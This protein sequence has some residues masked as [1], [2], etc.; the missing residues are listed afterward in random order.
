MNKAGKNSH[1]SI[2]AMGNFD[3]VHRGHQKIFE[4]LNT[5]A[6]QEGHRSKVVTFTPNPKVYFKREKFLITTY[7]QKKN[8]LETQGADQVLVIDFP[9]VMNLPDEQFIEEY[10]LE[11]YHMK[12]IVLGENFRFGKG[13]E[14]NI[15]SLKRAA[16]RLNFRFTVVKPVML[17]EIR[18]SSSLIRQQLNE[19]NI[20]LSNRMLGRKYFIE[21]V[22]V[23]G[24][25][26]GRQLGFPT[27]NIETPN[28]L[29]PEGV[30][31][32]KAEIDGTFHD[33][34]TY[35]GFRPTFMG[36]EKKLE[37]HI[38]DFDRDIYHQSVRIHFD[39]KIRGQMKFDDK[40]S[41]VDQIKKDIDKIKVDKEPIF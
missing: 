6:R 16:Q 33:S 22:V 9:S 39:R 12:H 20:Q 38:F 23:E 1:G 13:R 34:I 35:I 26:I 31:E 32:T 10:L 27:L 4:T 5:I 36:K 25:H 11:K 18:I 17:G 30:F 3:G 2:I 40:D 29:L 8:L 7:D 19:A 24:D 37:S 41:L 21:G 15:E 28:T 14:G